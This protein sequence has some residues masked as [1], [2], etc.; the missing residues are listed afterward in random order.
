MRRRWLITLF[1]LVVVPTAFAF[2]RTHPRTLKPEECSELYRRYADSPDIRATYVKNYRVND[3]LTLNATLLEAL[4]DTGWFEMCDCFNQ[5]AIPI[6]STGKAA[7]ENGFDVLS[8]IPGSY[9]KD[10]VMSPTDF[11]VFSYR[12]RYIC[13]FHDCDSI[14]QEKIMDALYREIFHS[15]K[16]NEKLLKNEKSI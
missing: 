8:L 7:I 10:S 12:D 4:T 13:A 2:V 6:S 3:T 15:L 16:T 1:L 14:E 11:A 9:P 5:S